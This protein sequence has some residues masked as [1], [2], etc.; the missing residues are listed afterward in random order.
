MNAT[1]WAGPKTQAISRFLRGK[2]ANARAAAAVTLAGYGTRSSPIS[3]IWESYCDTNAS[4]RRLPRMR[5]G[6]EHLVHPLRR[7]RAPNPL[8]RRGGSR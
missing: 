2:R 8:H 1:T 5:R 6:D 3:A 4:R 7:A